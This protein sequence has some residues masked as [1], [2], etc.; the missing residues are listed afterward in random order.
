MTELNACQ[1]CDNVVDDLLAQGIP[2]ET[3]NMDWIKLQAAIR[4]A[5]GQKRREV[6]STSSQRPNFSKIGL[7][8]EA[9]GSATIVSTD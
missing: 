9:N 2:W 1:Y 4:E 6:Y 5:E 7:Q 3:I 8:I